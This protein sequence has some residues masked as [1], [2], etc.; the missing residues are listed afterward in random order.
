MYSFPS[1]IETKSDA[2]SNIPIPV[3]VTIQNVI[4]LVFLNISYAFSL[5]SVTN[6]L[7]T[8]GVNSFIICR[9]KFC[10]ELIIK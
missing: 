9:I 6:K 2:T 7:P 10:I 8:L 4:N 1:Q 5:L 3:N